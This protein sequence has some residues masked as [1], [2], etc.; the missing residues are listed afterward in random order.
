MQQEK[1]R[2]VKKLDYFTSPGHVDGAGSRE[3]IGLREGGPSVVI[4]NMAVFRFAD[5]TKQMYLAGF[6]PGITPEQ[7]LE[8]MEFSG[9]ISRAVEVIPP[10]PEELRILREKC[11]PQRLIL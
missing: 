7:V 6:Y 3:R 5:E 11:D 10:T 2:F 9:D 4:T 8:N 1:K